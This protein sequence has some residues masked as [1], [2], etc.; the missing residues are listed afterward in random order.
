MRPGM[1]PHRL[2]RPGT[3]TQSDT[4]EWPLGR[5]GDGTY[6]EAWYVPCRDAETT[7]R[8]TARWMRWGEHRPGL[9]P[10]RRLG[11]VRVRPRRTTGVVLQ[12]ARAGGPTRRTRRVTRRRK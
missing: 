7:H 5:P 11:Q 1:A 9:V 3:S 12:R 8:L 10:R 2:G 6:A 4:Y